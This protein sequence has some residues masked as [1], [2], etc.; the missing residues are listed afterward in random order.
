[1]KAKHI[2]ALVGIL[3]FF[4]GSV[5]VL[6]KASTALH[7]KEER[8]ATFP[9]FHLPDL[10]GEMVSDVSIDSNKATVFYFFDPDCNLCVVMLDSLN[11]RHADFSDYQVLLLTIL[12]KEK[13]KEFVDKADFRLSENIKI[14]FDENAELISVLDVK[15][16]PTSLIYKDAKLIKRFDGPVTVETLIK[17]L[18]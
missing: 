4:A 18:Q 7:Q 3:L 8:Y 9:D 14:L 17:Y 10:D 13:I 11:K 6:H 2:I 12:S 1:M 15:G 16:A 5:F